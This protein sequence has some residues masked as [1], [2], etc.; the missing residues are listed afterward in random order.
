MNAQT[1][2]TLLPCPICGD[3]GEKGFQEVSVMNDARDK[4]RRVICRVCGCM[5]PEYNWNTRAHLTKPDAGGGEAELAAALADVMSWISNWTP[6]FIYDAEWPDSRERAV[7]ALA[8]YTQT[9]KE[10][11]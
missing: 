3:D 8:S 5:C 2:M 1:E 9:Q 4:Y 6:D 10:S 11:K 7:L